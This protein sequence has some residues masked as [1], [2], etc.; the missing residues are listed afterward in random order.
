MIF[1][2]EILA[3]GQCINCF[4]F[5]YLTRFQY[6]RRH[7]SFKTMTFH[8]NH[9]ANRIFVIVVLL[10]VC[11]TTQAQLTI[12]DRYWQYNGR[13]VMLLGG[14]DH[15]H[16]PFIDHDQEDEN[17]KQGVSSE[18]QIVAAMDELVDA[19]GNLLRCVLDPGMAA[20]IQ[21][22]NFCALSGSK[23]DLSEMTGPF[24]SRLEMFVSEAGK[25]DIIV[26]IELWDRFDIID[27]GWKSWP[28]SP[29]NPKNN[30]NYTTAESGLEESYASYIDH[31]FLH[32]VPGHPVYESAS[33]TRRKQFDLV[34]GFQNKF[35]D[36]LLSVTFKYDN[37]LYCMNNETHE[38]PAWGA[39]WID[40]IRKKAKFHGKYVLVTD[41]LDKMFEGVE[42]V[43]WQY[44]ANH[45]DTYDYIDV[46]QVN[47]R[48]C[49][50]DHWDCII[51]IAEDARH[52]NILLHMTK[53][54]GNDKALDGDPWS[55][56]RPGDSE[57]GIEEWWHNLL[58][59][60]AGV[61]FHRPPSGLGLSEPAK[62]NIKAARLVETKIRYRD[63]EPAQHLLSD[64]ESDEAYLAADPGKAYIL[65]F[66]ASG[67]GKVT[68]DLSKYKGVNFEVSWVDIG[69]DAWDES[70]STTIK[71]GSSVAVDRPA[72]GHW[73]AAIT[74]IK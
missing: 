27:G 66:P 65:Y 18:A 2:T 8:Q 54:Y 11:L 68:I 13:P 16:N 45:T 57:N 14:W 34:R 25:R 35:V 22:Q 74:R 59:G 38:D 9:P 69:R 70:K 53:L 67:E 62:N 26:Q 30:I 31:P 15:G 58:A 1:G 73:V 41:M 39:Y 48:H 50:Q 60:V 71:G 49:D 51:G 17:G 20:G 6:L 24:W 3:G 12:K 52:K 10:S 46:S 72:P 32:G 40:Y 64:R 19:G 7:K 44:M 33:E 43:D 47:S 37:I 36:K 55:R 29:F 61:R 63:V 42:S 28:V 23:Y 4:L 56:F 5:I 21:N